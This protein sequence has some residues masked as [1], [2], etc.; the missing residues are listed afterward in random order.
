MRVEGT[1]MPF[2]PDIVV[3]EP[4]SSHVLLI[5]EAKTI[6]SVSES[7]KQLR[8]Y[9]WEMSCPVGLLVSP[10]RIILYRN[11]FTGYSDDS[12]ERVGAYS[13]PSSWK[14]YVGPNAGVEFERRV[15]SWLEGLKNE[16]TSELA[17]EAAGA[18]EQFVIPGLLQG[19]IHAAGPRL[20]R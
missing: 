5:V 1:R 19:E 17:G 9:M 6:E 7:E 12:V 8:R 15:Q 2:D 16:R 4:G 18:F 13:A 11:L 10:R 3:T 14:D 20:I